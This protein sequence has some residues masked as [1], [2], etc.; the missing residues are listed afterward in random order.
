MAGHKKSQKRNI[1]YIWGQT[2]RKAI[3]MKLGTKIDVHEVVTWAK[4]NL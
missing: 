2:P 3:T 1:S 4:F